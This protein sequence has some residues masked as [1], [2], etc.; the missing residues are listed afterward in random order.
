M[1]LVKA[2]SH[3]DVSNESVKYTASFPLGPTHAWGC[4]LLF[5]GL[6]GER[7]FISFI[8]ISS[9]HRTIMKLCRHLVFLATFA[10]VLVS[11]VTSSSSYYRVIV[12]SMTNNLFAL[13]CRLTVNGGIGTFQGTVQWL[14][15]GLNYM[16]TEGCFAGAIRSGSTL[17]FNLTSEC[18]GYIQCGNATEYSQPLELTGMINFSV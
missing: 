17:R 13:R 2:I 10:L 4:C 15:N 16:E 18:D 9:L 14:Y 6:K 12:D 8:D 3:H 7:L 11:T 5:K 1:N